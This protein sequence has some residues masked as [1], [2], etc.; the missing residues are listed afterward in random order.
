VI[1]KALLSGRERV[2]EPPYQGSDTRRKEAQLAEA[3]LQYLAE[4]PDAQDTAEGIASFWVMRQKVKEE[5][6]DVL[7]VLRQLTKSGQ[8]EEVRRGDHV[9]YRLNKEKTRD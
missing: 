6:N 3:I 8:V 4:H 2:S 5:V 9:L 7:K 1:A